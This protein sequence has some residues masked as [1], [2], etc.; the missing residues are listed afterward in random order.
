MSDAAPAEL[1]AGAT[2]KLAAFG[3][4]LDFEQL[5]PHVVDHLKL[6]ILDGLGCILHGAALPWTARV[7]AMVAADGGAP[8]A[9]A[10]GLDARVPAAA[11]ALVNGTAG[12]AFELDD[13]HRDSIIHPNSLTLSVALALAERAGGRNGKFFLAAIAAGYEVGTRVG[14]A[15]GPGLLL[16]GF[17]PQGTTGTFAAAATAAR[18]LALDA[19]ATRQALGIAGSLGAGLMAAQEGAMVKRLHSGRAAETGLRAALLA[20]TGFTGIENVV[21]AG[22]GG[23]IT[24]HSDTPAPA[25]LL[26]GLG[27]DWEI[28]NTGF[29]PHATVTS[30]HACLDALAAIRREN[31]LEADDMMRIEAHVSTPTY[32]HCAWP[33]AARSVTAAQMNIFYGLAVMALDGEAFV[34]QFTQARIAD[35]AVMA[36]I[37]RIEASVDPEIDALGPAH[38]HTASV[39]VTTTDGRRF[40]KRVEARK[41]SPENPLGTDEIVAKFLALTAG[42]LT[43]KT[44]KAIVARVAALESEGNVC[45]L[46]ELMARAEV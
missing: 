27:R 44:A 5:P 11:A 21:E 6:C 4:A 37:E 10:F 17:H 24:A 3:A 36:V 26:G 19:N 40:E 14:A 46:V 8:E 22:Y 28:L 20:E 9:T 38:R 2:A 12:H 43:E 23:F 45:A 42:I 16:G 29:K 30:I 7:A 18:M 39:R 33:Y 35:A 34:R 32:V 15:A 13:I 1:L 31:G 25:R 41:G